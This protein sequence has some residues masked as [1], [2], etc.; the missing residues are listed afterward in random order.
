[1]TDAITFYFTGGTPEEVVFNDYSDWQD[2]IDQIQIVDESNVEQ[3]AF[4]RYCWDILSREYKGVNIRYRDPVDFLCELANVFQNRFFKFLKEK[5][6][7]EKIYNLTEDE[8]I[9]AGEAINNF[10][11]NPNTAPAES[12]QPLE[13]VSSQTYNLVKNNKVRAYIEA[14]SGL[15]TLQIY[16]FTKRRYGDNDIAFDDLFMNNIPREYRLY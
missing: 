6:I 12:K 11:N 13:F 16:D 10:A 4:S 3:V 5:E 1:M 14:L 2:F 15:P 7:I 8:Y 9:E